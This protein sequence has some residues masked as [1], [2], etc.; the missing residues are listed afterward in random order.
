MAAT[1]RSGAKVR[2][3]LHA[4]LIRAGAKDGSGDY[5]EDIVESLRRVQP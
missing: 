2:V 5:V 3:R 1:F 4:A